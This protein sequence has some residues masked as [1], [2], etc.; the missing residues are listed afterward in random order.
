MGVRG[1]HSSTSE[2]YYV[3]NRVPKFV[4]PAVTVFRDSVNER[5]FAVKGGCEGRGLKI[6]FY[7]VVFVDWESTM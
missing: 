7:C 6:G 2:T 5:M 3:L 1:G 4:T